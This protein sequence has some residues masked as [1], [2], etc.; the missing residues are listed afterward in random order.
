MRSTIDYSNLSREDADRAAL[1]DMLQYLGVEK[2]DLLIDMTQ[3]EVFSDDPVKGIAQINFYCGFAGVTGLP[4]FA[5]CRK[6]AKQAYR[7]WM[8]TGVHIVHTDSAGF[9]IKA[10]RWGDLTWDADLVGE[11]IKKVTFGWVS[12]FAVAPIFTRTG[13]IEWLVWD[14]HKPD[15]EGNPSVIRQE[16]TLDAALADIGWGN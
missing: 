11:P 14:A 1:K 10:D 5:F 7:Q 12:R 16:A 2:F 15:D 4:F 3:G 8:A 9:S 13:A 6:Y